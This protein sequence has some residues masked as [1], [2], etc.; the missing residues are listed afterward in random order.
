[1]TECNQ[2][3]FAFAPHFS[4]QVSARFS[5]QQLSTEGGALLLRETDRKIGILSRYWARRSAQRLE[6]AMG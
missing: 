6:R 2:N 3:E 1:M 5:E 4:R